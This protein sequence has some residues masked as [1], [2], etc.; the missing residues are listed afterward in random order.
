MS[1][2]VWMNG[3]FVPAETALVSVA[4]GGW[5]H[6]AGLFETM[7]C[8]RGVVFRFAR[9]MERLGRSCAALLRP[10]DPDSLPSG[11]QLGELAERNHLER[12]R[13]RL[14]VTSGALRAGSASDESALTLVA[15]ASQ[16]TEYPRQAFDDGVGV[17]I[18]RFR[19]SPLDPIAGHKSTCYLPRL[20]ALRAAQQ[21]RRFEALWFTTDHHLTEGCISN[22][23]LVRDETLR[24]PGL[25]TPVLP[26]IA[27]AT[28]IEL[29][30]DLGTTV[31][32]G[33]LT[34][35]DLLAAQEVLLT[36][37]MLGVLPV[38]A[39]ERH[40]VGDGRVGSVANRL[41]AAFDERVRREC[42]S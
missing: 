39:V 28:V 38:V 34:I 22:V 17:V 2:V 6:G 4:D 19:Q 30:R 23:F 36:N 29:A 14:T 9:H 13:I 24:T 1:E 32:E 20:V 8:E 35:D 18:S 27:R 40:A 10:V 33:P 5:L 25:D 26:G 12:A 31:Q 41:K 16:L 7:R 37:V 3:R 15:T 11:E 21:A 42:G